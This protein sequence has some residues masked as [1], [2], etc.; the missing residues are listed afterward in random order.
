M[1]AMLAAHGVPMRLDHLYARRSPLQLT[2]AP[3]VVS[4]GEKQNTSSSLR[5]ALELPILRIEEPGALVTRSRQIPE[6]EIQAEPLAAPAGSLAL[7]P[8]E[9]PDSKLQFDL[10]SSS[11]AMKEY[12]ATM[13]R[14]LDV[15]HRVMQSFL[16]NHGDLDSLV[17]DSTFMTR[18]GDKQEGE[19]HLPGAGQSADS[20]VYPGI[21]LDQ[22]SQEGSG[23]QDFALMREESAPVGSLPEES[24]PLSSEEISAVGIE[25]SLLA[26]VSEKTGYPVEMLDPTVNLE[27]DLGI[28]SIKRI[29]ILGALWQQQPSLKSEN[30]EKVA[31]LKSLREMATF[32][33]KPNPSATPD[34]ESEPNGHRQIE[35]ISSF[36]SLP[37]SPLLGELISFAP[38]EELVVQRKFDLFE[39]VFL[40]HHA[41][42]G[43]IALGD[44]ELTALPVMPLTMSMEILA[45]AGSTLVPD[46]LLT[47]MKDIRAY[48]WIALEQSSMTLRV[49]ARRQADSEEVE[50][51]LYN[52]DDKDGLADSPAVEGTMVFGSSY[53]EAPPVS[54]LSLRGEKASRGLPDQLYSEKMFHGPSWQGVASVDRCGDDGAIATLKV[55]PTDGLFRS[56]KNP[57]FVTDPIVLDAA[58]QVVGFWAMELL[59]E[60]F[61]VFP[62]SVKALHIY[63]TQQ[64]VQ[65]KVKC[66]AT[67]KLV[68]DQRVCSNI[69]M[70]TEEGELW[71]RLEEWEDRRFDPPGQAYPFL[72]APVDVTLS[73]RLDNSFGAAKESISL[74]CL[75]S[76]DLFKSDVHFWKRVFAH[77]VLNPRERE[78]FRTLGSSDK[79][80]IHWLLGRVVAKDAV[81]NFLK[82]KHNLQLGPADI[83][84]GQ[85]NHGRPIAQGRWI[86]KA[87]FAPALSLSHTRGATVAA[88]GQTPLR[89][90]IGVDIEQIRLIEQGFETMA[91]TK[92]ELALLNSM[93]EPE[94]S[95]WLLRFWC[96]KEAVGK[97]LGR[98]LAYGPKSLSV[99]I[100]NIETG[101]LEVALRG[102][103]AEAFPRIAGSPVIVNSYQENDYVV[104]LAICKEAVHDA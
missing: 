2:L 9:T 58:G 55:L 49:I 59:E 88:V 68:G 102:K 11:P 40:R 42:G 95:Q 87:E 83:E 62:Y 84:I 12:F 65:Q 45:E 31:G 61:L 10:D 74:Y 81:R 82:E 37:T 16:S 39:D 66:Q 89:G 17:P 22:P 91:S 73:R 63:R 46:K 30:L 101:E 6:A 80:Q 24:Q 14:F 104:A 75:R 86:E 4:E 48:R 85:D 103:L 64:P 93:V 100:L 47:G 21:G 35:K 52:L 8:Q 96:A 13:E 5:L 19:Q 3:E 20:S 32:L 51:K 94:R 7:E 53:P 76:E 69:D 33:S 36:E 79:R 71:M 23:V 67:I 72:L 38:G 29:E 54:P 50:V 56:D 44:K 1:V 90:A 25:S 18:A 92:Q 57:K 78:V 34:S 97:A 98:G 27:A 77:L 26:I 15:Q 28:D 41:L 60:R 43:Q 70:I 99:N